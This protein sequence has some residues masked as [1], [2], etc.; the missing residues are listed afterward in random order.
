VLKKREYMTKISEVITT[1][2]E[3]IERGAN[4]LFLRSLFSFDTIKKV[5]TQNLKYVL[6]QYINCL[7]II[8]LYKLYGV[9]VV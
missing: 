1:L 3:V 8:L 6:F 2:N 5:H 4:M 9:Y 7:I